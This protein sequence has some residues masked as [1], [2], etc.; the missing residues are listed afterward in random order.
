MIEETQRAIDKFTADRDAKIAHFRKLYPNEDLVL[1]EG[2]VSEETKMKAISFWEIMMEKKESEGG[3]EFLLQTWLLRKQDALEYL[4]A[5]YD[6][7][8]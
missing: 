2:T 4:E 7:K 8:H 5:D 1:I 3:N 6:S